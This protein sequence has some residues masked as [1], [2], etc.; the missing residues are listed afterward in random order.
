MFDALGKALAGLA[1][2]LAGALGTAVGGP[3][4]GALARTAVGAVGKALGLDTD[5]PN[6]VSAALEK[7]TPEQIA[8]IKQADQAF[9]ARMRELDLH[10]VEI[11][12]RDRDSARRR[13]VVTRDRMP[14]F[15]ALAALSGFFG[16]LASMILI[17]IPADAM[18]P[19]MVMLGALGALVTQIGAFY[20]GSSAG[21]A[22]KNETISRLLANNGTGR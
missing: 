17:A 2:T 4:G 8:A 12:A 20:F 5:D 21:S 1:P 3:V 22:K 16:I 13:Q 7:A 10:E 14:A 15:I 6:E 18:Q 11:H 19:L 9:A